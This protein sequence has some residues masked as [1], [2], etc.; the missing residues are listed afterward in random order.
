MS[1]LLAHGVQSRHMSNFG[2]WATKKPWYEAK[3]D[4]KALSPTNHEHRWQI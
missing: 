4:A 3:K 2:A 1:S